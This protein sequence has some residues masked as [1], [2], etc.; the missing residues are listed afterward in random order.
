MLTGCM[1]GPWKQGLRSDFS[2]HL[3]QGLSQCLAHSRGSINS[4]ALKWT[5]RVL[6]AWTALSP[7]WPSGKA[8]DLGHPPALSCH[9][10][11]HLV[12]GPSLTPGRPSPSA[13]GQEDLPLPQAPVCSPPWLPEW[14][15]VS[16]ATGRLPV[17]FIFKEGTAGARPIN[18]QTPQRPK[19]N[20]VCPAWLQPGTKG[21]LLGKTLS[22]PPGG[23]HGGGGV[24]WSGPAPPP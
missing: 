22:L 10:Y 12:R 20:K 9:R 15:P 8:C 18:F 24:S 4:H 16:T 13:Q 7:S 5:F 2:Q 6:T 11:H 14:P 17:D 1:K 3:L 21:D 23:R 19:F